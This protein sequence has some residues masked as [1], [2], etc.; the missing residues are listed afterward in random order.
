VFM[1]VIRL[2]QEAGRVPVSARLLL[3]FLEQ[4]EETSGEPHSHWNIGEH[5]TQVEVAVNKLD[6]GQHADGDHMSCWLH[7]FG[8]SAMRQ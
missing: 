4:P 2:P 8:R 6:V 5:I 7:V 1:L 3:T